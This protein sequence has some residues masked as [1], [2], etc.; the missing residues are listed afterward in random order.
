MQACPRP[1]R[2][3]SLLRKRNGT[4]PSPAHRPPASSQGRPLWS[5]APDGAG[6]RD[7]TSPS[8]TGVPAR[9]GT[10]TPP[11]KRTAQRPSPAHRP[12]AAEFAGR[13]LWSPAPDG[14]GIRD[15]TS[16]SPT[17]VPA[18]AGT[19]TPPRKRDGTTPV[20][21]ASSAGEFV[22]ATLV[23]A[24]AGRGGDSGRDKPVPYGCP[25]PRRDID[26]ATETGR[27]NA[28]TRRIVRRR[29]RRGDPCGRPR[30][31]GRGFGTGQARPLR[32]SPRP[33]RDIDAAT[34][35]GRHNARPRRIVPA[36]PSSQGDPC[37]RPRRT[38]RGFGTGQAR[39]LRVSPPAPGHRRRHG[40]GT[41][42]RP[43]PAHRPGAAEFVG[44]T[45]VVARAGRDGDSGRDKPVPYGCPRPRRDIDAATETDGTTP[46]PGGS[47]AGEFV[48]ATLVVA[49]AGRGGDSGRD[50]PV[51]YGWSPPAP[52]HRR[53]HGD[54]RDNARP[55]RIVRRRVRRGDPCGR[56]RRTGRGFGTG[57]ARPLRDHRHLV[58]EPIGGVDLLHHPQHVAGVDVD[59]AGGAGVEVPIRDDALQGAV[60]Q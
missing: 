60:E 10:S 39:P 34:E 15:G 57:Q 41:A 27:H 5:P 43:Y 35:T 7:G 59:R 25:R 56:P 2:A 37:G 28:R 29:V 14:A 46:V 12:G 11:R 31:T 17:G 13:P 18:R 6:I 1:H 33:R 3:L 4:T 47:S 36:P 55:R 51:P 26:A 19:S 16:P 8:P 20:P 9:A 21:G 30:R 40:D 44:A 32:V 49:R 54:G 53:R 50:K 52:G 24:R 23:V 42:Q 48:G 58:D 45:L 38:G 22:G